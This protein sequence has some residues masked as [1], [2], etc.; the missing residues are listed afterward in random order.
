MMQ[1]KLETGV[2][3]QYFACYTAKGR[4]ETLLDMTVYG[5]R[6]TLEISPGRIEW[7]CGHD[8]VNVSR[9]PKSDRGYHRQWQNFC[10]AITGRAAVVSTP[11]KALD[12]L[13]VIDA[14]LRAA[15]AARSERPNIAAAKFAEPAGNETR[16]A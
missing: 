10:D 2:I 9:V 3:G 11:Q 13:L 12:D 16:R 8:T 5:S 6:G 14:A 7:S 15:S 4:R 1:M